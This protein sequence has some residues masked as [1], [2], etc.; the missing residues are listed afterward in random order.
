MS[1]PS[2]LES[3]GPD[4]AFEVDS[5]YIGRVPW[6]FSR[7]AETVNGR[8]A[9]M[10]FTVAYLQEAIVG[11]GVLEQYGLPYDEGAILDKAGFDGPIFAVLGLVFAI[12][13]TAALSFAGEAAFK[14]L[15]DPKYDGT[16]LP[17]NPLLDGDSS[18]DVP[19]MKMP[20]IKLPDIK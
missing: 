1:E 6:G 5:E 16:S 20:D 15:V 17:G 14:K 10:G 9:M 4:P 2:I 7:N 18:G 11:K 3:E 13:L 8:F 19:D 12:V